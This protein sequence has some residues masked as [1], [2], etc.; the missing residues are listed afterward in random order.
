MIEQQYNKKNLVFIVAKLNKSQQ[1]RTAQH[2]IDKHTSNTAGFSN[3]R[4][5]LG[6]LCRLCQRRRRRLNIITRRCWTRAA[7]WRWGWWSWCSTTVWNRCGGVDSTAGGITLAATAGLH[8][9]VLHNARQHTAFRRIALRHL[10]QTAAF[11]ATVLTLC[12]IGVT[13]R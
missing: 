6:R 3:H 12:L 7:R 13:R 2:N 4:R 8:T 5:G 11:S 10:R 1:Q 9:R